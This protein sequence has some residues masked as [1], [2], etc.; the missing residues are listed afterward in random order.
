ML[1]NNSLAR[2][3]DLHLMRRLWHVLC[4]VACLASYYVMDADII[5][6]G[7]FSLFIA[8]VSFFFDFKRFSSEKLN[9]SVERVMG[10]I[11]RH[12]EKMSFSGLSFYALGVALSIFLYEKNVAILSILYLVFADP[13]A[14]IVGYYYGKDRLLPNKTLQG[15]IAA[16]VTCLVI[17]LV[18][19]YSQSLLSSNIIIFGFLAAMFGAMSELLSAFNID[20]NLTIPVISGAILSALNLWFGVF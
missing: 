19:F 14:S 5:Y 13:I 1:Q 11:M 16:F 6:W 20:D 12:S 4:G 7:Y 18:Y 10:P 3:S 8:G 17:T 15:T 2:R 9:T